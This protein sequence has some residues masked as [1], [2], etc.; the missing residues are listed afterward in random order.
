MKGSLGYWRE[1]RDSYNGSGEGFATGDYA[2]AVTSIV[3]RML[4][5]NGIR[6]SDVVSPY[7]QITDKNLDDWAK[8]DWS[9]KTPGLADGPGGVFMPEQFVNGLF[10]DGQSG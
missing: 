2:T 3:Q 8:A 4:G 9:L 6:V 7:V 5:G 1:N 10:K